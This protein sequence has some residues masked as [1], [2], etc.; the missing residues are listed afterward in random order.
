MGQSRAASAKKY[1]SLG[2]DGKEDSQCP[3]T[4]AKGRKRMI[5]YLHAYSIFDMN[6]AG[7]TVRGVSTTYAITVG[8]ADAT[9]S[10]II[11]PD[12]DQVK[13]SIWPGVSTIT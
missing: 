4:N 11:A 6:V 1:R 12:A 7:A 5:T 9:A 13:I 2:G 8:S 3:S 10:V